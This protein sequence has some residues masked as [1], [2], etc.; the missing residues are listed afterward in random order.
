MTLFGTSPKEWRRGAARLCRTGW[1]TGSSR[2]ERHELLL[3]SGRPPAL[4]IRAPLQI[5]VAI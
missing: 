1:S 4:G 3:V 2:E 5:A